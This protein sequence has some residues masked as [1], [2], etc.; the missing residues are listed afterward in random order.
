MAL[1]IQRSGPFNAHAPAKRLADYLRDNDVDLGLVD[2]ILFYGYPKFRDRFDELITGEFVLVSPHHGMLVLSTTAATRSEDEV[3]QCERELDAIVAKLFAACIDAP[4]LRLRQGL[5]VQLESAIYAPNCSCEYAGQS[6]LLSSDRSVAKWLNAKRRDHSAYMGQMLA[7]IDGSRP[8]IRAK[9]RELKGLGPKAKGAT[10]AELEAAL[11][12]FDAKQRGGIVSDIGGPQ[13]IRG[14]AGTGKTVI[15]AKKA[16]LT[17]LT[18]PEARIGFTFY[19]KSLYQHVKQQ[20]TRLYRQMDDRDPDWTNLAVMHAW[21]GVGTPGVYSEA[22]RAAGETPLTFAQANMAQS[23]APFEAACRSLLATGRVRPIFD[24]LFVDEGQDY[25]EAFLTLCVALTK[26]R[27]FVWAY[28]DL[29]TIFQPK[30]P[31]TRHIVGDWERDITLDKCYRNPSEVLICAHALGLGVY[32]PATQLLEDEEHWRDVGYQ[33]IFGELVPGEPV[34]FERVPGGSL[35]IVSDRYRLEEIVAGRH[36][37]SLGEEV[38]WVANQIATD[39][40]DGVRPD[41]V[42]VISVD[43]RNAKTYLRELEVAL[44]T[45]SIDSYNVHA[46]FGATDFQHPDRVTL[47]TVHKA[48]GNEAFIV[49]AV[50]VDALFDR[51]TRRKRNVLFTAMTRSKGWLRLT[52]VGPAAVAFLAELDLAKAKF[53]ALEFIY[54]QAVALMDRDNR[55]NTERDTEEFIEGM[56]AAQLRELIASAQRKLSKK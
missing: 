36:F 28:D 53:P 51:V 27:K 22:C 17:H 48:K 56:S 16:A 23:E 8:L 40:Q 20:I 6:Q 9:K 30:A 1:D 35:S 44:S 12:T 5:R 55:A 52:G 49:Y 32:G 54:P 43:D 7:A 21:G 18:D 11:A 41:D 34:R 4:E 33:K 19:T 14:L 46:G 45:R 31:D 38:E 50:G 29:Q 25:P 15:L 24:Y 47:S 26:D 13:R 37:N 42:T 3:G 10:I 39:L 2:A